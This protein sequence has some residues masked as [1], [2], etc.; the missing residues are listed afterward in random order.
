MAEQ[1]WMEPPP[2]W[3]TLGTHAD[4]DDVRLEFS[5]YVV[6]ADGLPLWE[7]PIDSGVVS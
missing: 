4:Q 2:G 7:R 5:T 1:V 3:F 6:D